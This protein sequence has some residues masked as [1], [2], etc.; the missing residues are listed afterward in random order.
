MIC[1][2]VGVPEP[3]VAVPDDLLGVA[4]PNGI[5]ASARYAAATTSSIIAGG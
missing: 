5:A 1:R 2:T 4:H 3:V